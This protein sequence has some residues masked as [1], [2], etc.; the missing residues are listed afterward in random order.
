MITIKA[1]SGHA[2]EGV[3]PSDRNWLVVFRKMGGLPHREDSE[4]Y[5]VDM[6]MGE[7]LLEYR[8]EQYARFSGPDQ[9]FACV[10]QGEFRAIR[11]EKRRLMM[12]RGTPE[13]ARGN[14]R[15]NDDC[16]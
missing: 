6:A 11:H 5:E 12:F 16:R 2:V 8:V 3:I 14:P 7:L 9:E 15:S 13:P 4:L 1:P 10:Y